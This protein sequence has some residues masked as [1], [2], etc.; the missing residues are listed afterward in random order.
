MKIYLAIQRTGWLK[1]IFLHGNNWNINV[2]I[3]NTK[4]TTICLYLSL[5]ARL[6]GRNCYTYS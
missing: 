1:G 6:S 2:L 3:F 5:K 4:Y